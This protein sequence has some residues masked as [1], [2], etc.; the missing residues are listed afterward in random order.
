MTDAAR[1]EACARLQQLPEAMRALPQ[2]LLWRYEQRAGEPKPRKV[3]YYIS[4]YARR[5]TQGSDKD[6]SNLCAFDLAVQRFGRGNYDGIGFAFLP[7][8]GL[9]GVDIDNGVDPDTGEISELCQD[10]IGACASYTETSP[11]GKGVH[12]ILTGEPAAFKSDDIG[13]EVYAERQYFTCTGARWSTRPAEATPL[14]PEAL[15]MLRG[16]VDAAKAAADQAKQTARRPPKPA[17][18]AV[19]SPTPPDK[20]TDFAAVNAL[21]LQCLDHWVPD[22]FPTASKS[23]NGTWRVTSKALGRKLEEDLSLHPDGIKDFGTEQ[24]MTPIDV[25]VEFGKH[26]PK[27]ALHWLASRLGMTLQGPPGKRRAAPAPAPSADAAPPADDAPGAPLSMDEGEAPPPAD[28][29]PATRAPKGKGGSKKPRPVDD[30]MVNR[31]RD[32]FALI[33]GTDTAFDEEQVKIIKV[34]NLRL[35]YGHD[36]VKIW[37]AVRHKRRLVQPEQIQFEPGRELEP[38]CINLWR[39]FTMEPQQGDVSVILELMHHLCSESGNTDVEVAQ[40]MVWA[41]RWLALPLQRP[42]TKMRSALVFHGPQGAGKNLLFEIMCKVYGQYALVVGQDQLEDKFNDWASQ[43]LFLIGDEVV[44]KAELFH[45]KNKLKSFITG[46]TIQI[47]TKMLPLRTEANHV[48]VVFLSN[49][50]QPLALE[51]GDRR[52]FVIWTP[53]RRDDD[54]YKRV[55]ACLDNG[56][57]RAWM[58]YLLKLDLHGQTEFDIPPMTQAK[59]DLIELGQRPHERFLREWL[60]GF[61]PLP[62]QVCSTDQLYRAFCTWVQRMGERFPPPQEAF[63]KGINKASR[64]RP[65][66]AARVNL[67]QAKLS[68]EVNGKRWLRFWVPDGCGQPEYPPEAYEDPQFKPQTKGE[69]AAEAVIAF[70]DALGRYTNEMS[71]AR[72]LDS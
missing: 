71:P 45:Q 23:G 17:P 30:D 72:R 61:L 54:L 33:Y 56:G 6:R 7:G 43:K 40:N 66:S 55:A 9:V 42:G 15:A 39:G 53:A 69:W 8:D 38:P 47:N 60:D 11:S 16:R 4:G 65:A 1:R 24:G 41:L 44:A 2:W 27:D 64:N 34:N 46:E 5:G 21:A 22:L 26:T 12:I 59:Q 49:E 35:A 67:D 13:L 52:F 50:Q 25:L 19:Q 63:S 29:V 62:C 31:L 51:V 37:L 10:V 48:N 3:P 14:T 70:E 57:A 20:G 68:I 36:E 32:K 58:D 28:S 18:A